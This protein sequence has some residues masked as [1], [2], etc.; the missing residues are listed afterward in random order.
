[1]GLWATLRGSSPQQVTL[2]PL[3]PAQPPLRQT[4]QAFAGMSREEALAF[5]SR[6]YDAQAAGHSLWSDA[7]LTARFLSCC[8]RSG[9]Q[10]TISGYRRELAHLAR[11][12][13]A[14]CPGTPLRLL[15]PPTAENAVADLRAQVQEGTLAPRTFNRRISCWSALWRWASEPTRSG[16]T[17]IARNIWPRRCL[18]DAPKVAKALAE[19]ELT[20]VLGVVQAA[21]IAGNPTARRDHVMLR[22]GYLLG[23]RVSELRALRWGDIERLPDGGIVTIRRGKG[24]K[25]RAVRVSTATI[26][27][28]ESLG[29]GP[30]E[31]WLFPS[32][33][34]D[35]PI[36]R[37]AIAD[38]FARWGRLAGVHVHPHRLRHSHA[39]AAIRAGCD[40]FTL[41]CSLG[42]ASTATTAG[43]VAANPA[44]SSSLRLG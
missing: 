27:L 20:A 30:E 15:D 16:V 17:G 29:R 9:S 33:R 13:E 5:V 19:P 11:W 28:I 10:E 26:D 14:H 7:E 42:H 34:S 25:F 4:G 24:G 21:A 44:D 8:S 37:Q 23:V 3:P 39:T 18:L 6:L 22:A 43:Y 36:S 12:I 40:V 41:Q 2:T 35:G 32:N 38:R 31:A 1:M